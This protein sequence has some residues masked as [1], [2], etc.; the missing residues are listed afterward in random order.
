M[1]KTQ[2][3]LRCPQCSSER[4]Y[5][6]GL[7]YLKNGLSVQRWLCRKCGY[8]FTQPHRNNSDASQHIQKVHRQILNSPEALLTNCQGSS[9]AKSRAPIAS[10]AV[11]TLVEAETRTEKQAAGAT[12]KAA[13]IKGK[14]V[15]CIWYMEKQGY[16][17]ETIRTTNGALRILQ[18]RGANLLDTDSV[19]EVIMKQPWSDNRRKNVINSY[20]LFLKVNGMQWEKPKCKIARKIPFIPTEQEI[21]ALIASSNKKLATFLQLLKETAMRS[22]EA[23][24]LKWTDVD[25]ERRII[26]LNEPEKNSNPRIWNISHKLTAMLNALPKTSPKIFGEGPISSLKSSLQLARKRL[27][28]KL[29]NPRLLQ[30]HFH[31]LR[32]WKATMEYHRTK[33]PLHVAALLG[34]KK[35]ENIQIYVQLDKNLFK[36]TDD[37]FI[38]KVAHNVG[39][40]IELIE[41]GFE[42]VTGEYNDGGKLFRKRK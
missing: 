33:D 1:T 5:K 12:E 2:K 14:I 7:R 37:D 27:A 13:D 9:E 35:L 23:K 16:A 17:K 21:D 42:Y 22:G 15:A 41:A 8:R 6:D 31:T 29:Q 11:Q 30:I 3:E 38:C 36:D 40:A 18:Q 25:L 34:H 24:R 19:K 4:L 20:N 26:I 10:K 28:Q 32:H 39:E